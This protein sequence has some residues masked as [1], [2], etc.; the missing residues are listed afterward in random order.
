M[1]KAPLL[2]LIDEALARTWIPEIRGTHL[3]G[4]RACKHEL[5]NVFR[6]AD[7]TDADN[8]NAYSIGC[9]VDH[10]ES[11][12]LDGRAGESSDDVGDARLARLGIDRHA[13]EGVHE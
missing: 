3:D 13:D 12:G 9:L 7:T 1:L 5:H 11:D 6:G 10:A 2:K 8:R 4:S